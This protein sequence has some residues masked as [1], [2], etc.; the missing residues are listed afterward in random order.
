MTLALQKATPHKAAAHQPIPIGVLDMAKM[1]SMFLETGWWIAAARYLTVADIDALEDNWRTM[2]IH[3]V[4]PLTWLYRPTLQTPE[5]DNLRIL[6]SAD[7]IAADLH[8]AFL[9]QL[10]DHGPVAA[11][12]FLA[13]LE[14]RRRVAHEQVLA[15]YRSVKEHNEAVSHQATEIG[16]ALSDT[17]FVCEIAIAV[18]VCVLS[19]GAAPAFLAGGA[20]ALSQA[21]AATT[22]ATTYG[23]AS[24]AVKIE[25]LNGLKGFAAEVGGEYAL[26]KDLEDAG[27]AAEVRSRAANIKRLRTL[28]THTRAAAKVEALNGELAKKISGLKRGALIAQ[29]LPQSATVAATGVQAGA[30][31]KYSKAMHVGG[32]VMPFI[33]CGYDLL[34]AFTGQTERLK[35]LAD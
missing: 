14:T 3:I 19:L 12:V 35:Q 22:L 5:G 16:Y 11:K 2:T 7:I 26:G 34:S 30:L 6:H 17:I 23:I 18:G 29:R 31:E 33:Q 4:I 9:Q 13:S 20:S 8:E 25:D 10:H 28:Q 15:L 32:K 27:H 21:A 24:K 1:S